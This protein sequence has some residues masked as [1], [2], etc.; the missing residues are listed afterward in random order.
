MFKGAI[1]NKGGDKKA[2]MSTLEIEEITIR[3]GDDLEIHS[4]GDGSSTSNAGGRL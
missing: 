2:G 3:S 4:Y 1:I